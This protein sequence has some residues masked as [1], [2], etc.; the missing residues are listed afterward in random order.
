VGTEARTKARMRRGI[1]VEVQVECVP[2]IH[3]AVINT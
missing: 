2:H 3:L 1:G